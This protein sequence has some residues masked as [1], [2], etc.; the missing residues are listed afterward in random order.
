MSFWRYCSIKKGGNNDIREV[1]IEEKRR[2][3]NKKRK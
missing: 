3:M 1:R 2:K